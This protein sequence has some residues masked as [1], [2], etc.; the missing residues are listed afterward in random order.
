[1][2]FPLVGVLSVGVRQAHVNLWVLN[3]EVLFSE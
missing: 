2:N 1:M 3:L